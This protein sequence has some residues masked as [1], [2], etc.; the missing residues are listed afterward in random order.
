MAK[1]NV[2]GTTG[3]TIAPFAPQ[4]QEDLAPAP[5][6][7]P[8]AGPGLTETPL[9]KSLQGQGFDLAPVTD[10]EEV[11][12]HTP[13]EQEAIERVA[14]L[15]Q[16][17]EPAEPAAPREADDFIDIEDPFEAAIDRGVKLGERF[18]T[19]TPDALAVRENRPEAREQLLAGQKPEAY[20]QDKIYAQELFLSPRVM[21]AAVQDPVTGK[22]EVSQ[23]FFPVMSL[24]TENF[25]RTSGQPEGVEVEGGQVDFDIEAQEQAEEAALAADRESTIKVTRAQGNKRLGQQIWRE[26]QREKAAAEGAPT[27]QYL[28][29]EGNVKPEEFEAIGGLAKELYARTN[30]DLMNRAEENG[31]IVYWPTSEGLASMNDSHAALSQP[32]ASQEIVPLHAPSATG[33][34][35]YEGKT[36]T[37][38]ETTKVA[39]QEKGDM[40]VIQE[41]KANLSRMPRVID[42]RREGLVYALGTQALLDFEAGD[43]T[44]ADIFGIGNE[45]LQGLQGKKAELQKNASTPREKKMAESFDPQKILRLE[46]Q[47]FIESIQ[48]VGRYASK[49]NYNTFYTIMLNGRLGMQQNKFNPQTNKVVRFAVGSGNKVKIF[50][51]SNSPENMFFKEA[52][53]AALFKQGQFKGKHLKPAARIKEFN[54]MY[55]A[56]ELDKYI[57]MGNELLGVIPTGQNLLGLRQGA[58][59]IQ[60]GPDGNIIVPPNMQQ[61]GLKVSPATLRE[62]TKHGDEAPYFAEMLTVLADWDKA[63]KADVPFNTNFEVEMDGI[64]HGPSSNAVALGS[65]EMALRSGTLNPN[66]RYKLMDDEGQLGD[67]RDAMREYMIEHGYPNAEMEYGADKARGLN[68]I[69]KRAVRDRENFLKKSPMTLGYGQL[70]DSLTQHVNTTMVEGPEAHNIRRLMQVTGLDEK[71]VGDYLHGQLVDSIVSQMDENALEVANLLRANAAIATFTD[72]LLKY[73][74]PMGFVSYI[75]GRARDVEAET[76]SEFRIQRAEEG[77][78]SATIT[79]YKDYGSGSAARPGREAGSYAFG[80]I[81]PAIVQAYDGNMIARTA[82]G[83]SQRR[84]QRSLEGKGYTPSWLPIFDAAKVD[85]AHGAVLREEM[86]RNWFDGIRQNNYVD[87]VMGDQAWSREVFREWYKGINQQIREGDKPVP[88]GPDTPLRAFGEWTSDGGWRQ[89]QRLLQ[90]TAELENGRPISDEKAHQMTGSILSG[91]YKKGGTTTELKPSQIKHIVDRYIEAIRLGPRNRGMVQKVKNKRDQLFAD[92]DVNDLLQVDLG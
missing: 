89:M 30:P 50:P 42:T 63:H 21:D 7:T 37:R 40:A 27:D 43:S 29:R 49:V 68:A 4:S 18:Q 80:R 20:D 26:W 75:G 51:R 38:R 59:Q 3:G 66:N 78:A 25:F 81:I 15:S 32:F 34:H 36:L 58:Q 55:Y 41:A 73:R 69:L 77:P 74:N 48:T 91:L 54:R 85:M 57:A 47:K 52:V 88:V 13:Q 84:I 71:T 62:I 64:T 82:S 79:H 17:I 35:E 5:A 87:E 61:A 12:E 70:I 31:Q 45:K 56:G 9:V 76:Q 72:Q 39:Q 11:V 44:L 65:R 67:L 16:R 23:D 28:A 33:Q 46:Q 14:P 2:P 8:E 90:A 6:Q 19:D 1:F 53:S 92:I 60:R 24:V 83:S 10:P 86:N 22:A